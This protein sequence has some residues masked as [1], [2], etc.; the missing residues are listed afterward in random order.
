M[1][2][3]GTTIQASESNPCPEMGQ[4]GRKKGDVEEITLLVEG[5]SLVRE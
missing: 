5:R 2:S 3:R 4:L 1:G